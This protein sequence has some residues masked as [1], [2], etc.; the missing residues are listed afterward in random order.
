[1]TF[2]IQ[3]TETAYGPRSLL[4][5]PTRVSGDGTSDAVGDYSSLSRAYVSVT[6]AQHVTPTLAVTLEH[7]D[8]GETWT[9]AADPITFTT[10]ATTVVTV[11]APKQYLRLA[12]S[13]PGRWTLSATVTPTSI[14]TGGSLT[15]TDGDT[16]VVASAIQ[17]TPGTIADLGD[18]VA[19]VVLNCQ[20]IGPFPI[21][22]NTPNI[23]QGDGSV[24]LVDIPTGT[25]VL[26]AWLVP[27]DTWAADTWDAFWIGLSPDA[28]PGSWV[29]I[30]KYEA[31]IS[32][33]TFHDQAFVS[34][35]A[36]TIDLTIAR[37]IATASE[38]S[39]LTVEYDSTNPTAG[40]GSVYAVIATPSA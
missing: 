15:V 34:A 30:T 36:F 25:S 37:S 26:T 16:S 38:P 5:N 9:E 18:G 3:A 12:W 4:L 27:L 23:D 7:S 11:D 20:L 24:N 2:N 14:D 6:A 39:H 8:D 1:M 40:T 21:A 17:F 10:T 28:H 13:S 22:F 35:E 19:G 32:G 33:G 29:P 31:G